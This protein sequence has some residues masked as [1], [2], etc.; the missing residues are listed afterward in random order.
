M[1]DDFKVGS[2]IKVVSPNDDEI[3]VLEKE[4]KLDDGHI[5]DALDIL[6]VPRLEFEEETPY[7]FTR[8]PTEAT[9]KFTTPFLIILGKTFLATV[10]REE[11]DIFDKFLEGKINF[12]TTQKIKFFIQIFQE[13]NNRYNKSITQISRNIYDVTTEL[14]KVNNKQI[15]QLVFYE[16]RLNDYLNALLRNSTILNTLLSGKSLV[17]FQDDREMIED[18]FLASEQLVLLAKNSLTTVKNIRDAYSAILTNN[19]N[20]VIKLLTALTIILT[21]PTMI[22]SFFGMNVDLPINESEIGFWIIALS[23][24]GI[25]GLIFYIFYRNDWM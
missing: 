24:L 3:E 12:F 11:Y 22:A 19:L 2:W 4:F 6:E 17:L 21:V 1:L 15:G 14:D 20:R 9:G 18:L 5:R 23:A 8:I 25:S 13:I 7:I 16:Q 10:S